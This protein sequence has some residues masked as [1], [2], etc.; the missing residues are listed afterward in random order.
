MKTK[1]KMQIK[2]INIAEIIPYWRNPRDNNEAIQVVVQSIKDYGFNVPLV[3]DKN[4]TIITGHTRYKALQ[5]LGWTEIPCIISDMD[6]KKA[7]EYRIADNKTSELSSWNEQ[8]LLL[9][10]REIVDIENFQTYFPDIELSSII[11]DSAGLDFKPINQSEVDKKQD[12][13]NTHFQ[14]IADSKSDAEIELMC[15]YCAEKFF[16]KRGDILTPLNEKH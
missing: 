5:V 14:D 11:T 10:L 12:S 7:K 3:L 13:L 6:E 15:P 16:V 8:N 2:N 9:E 1:S 4:N